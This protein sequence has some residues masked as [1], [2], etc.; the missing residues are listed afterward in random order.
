[1]PDTNMSNRPAAASTLDDHEKPVEHRRQ[2]GLS[3]AKELPM[4]DA[5]RDHVRKILRTYAADD[6]AKTAA[7]REI[8]ASGGKIITGGQIFGDEWE[9]LDWR[10][11]TRIA[12]GDGGMQGYDE[13]CARL[14]PEDTWRHIDPLSESLESSEP[15][16]TDGVPPSLAQ[17]LQE[18]IDSTATPD[19][20]IAEV[21]DWDVAEVTRCLRA[22]HP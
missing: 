4:S 7:I 19:E 21:A 18:W 16:P 6:E 12:H 2:V 11:G 3:T 22:D 1:M 14:D 17:A 8:E 13:T 15:P 10:T 20:E 5:I 9:I